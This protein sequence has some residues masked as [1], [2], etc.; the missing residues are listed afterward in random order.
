MTIPFWVDA[1][2]PSIPGLK[3]DPKAP[4]GLED[5]RKE[6]CHLTGNP[7]PLEGAVYASS[8][9]IFRVS[10]VRRRHYS[11]LTNMTPAGHHCTRNCGQGCSQAS[12]LGESRSPGIYICLLGEPCSGYYK[13]S[14]RGKCSRCQ[15]LNSYYLII[16]YDG[17]LSFLNTSW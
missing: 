8:W 11:C 17:G 10:P 9:M 15:A 16:L 13:V 1:S 12:I 4:L 14:R 5:V 7:Y 6:Y 2:H 3:N